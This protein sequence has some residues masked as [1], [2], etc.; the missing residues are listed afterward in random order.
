ME[1]EREIG[2]VID[3]RIAMGCLCFTYTPLDYPSH[4]FSIFR[5]KSKAKLAN[6]NNRTV[7]AL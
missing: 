7:E 1:R 5:G 3:G 2:V 4:I 6:I